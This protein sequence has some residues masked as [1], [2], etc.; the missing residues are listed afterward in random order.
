MIRIRP[1]AAAVCAALLLAA[2]GLAFAAST[3]GGASKSDPAS[4]SKGP[5]EADQLYER[6]LELA[7]EQKFEEALARFEQANKKR[8]KDAEILNMLAFCQRK[9]G[10]LDA[11][12]ENYGKALE[13][14]PRFPQAR[15]YLAEAHL[16]AALRELEILRG[17]G[18]E[19]EKETEELVTAIRR[20]SAEVYH[21]AGAEG[22]DW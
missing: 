18:A 16:Q 3:G 13:I 8:K 10:D 20:M 17:Y 5:D 6:G 22:G 4:E 9:T 12:F 1:R 14:Q 2:S 19:G 7:K 11:A 15:E 21:D